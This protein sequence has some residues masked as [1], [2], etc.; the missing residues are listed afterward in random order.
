MKVVNKCRVCQAALSLNFADLG[1]SPPAN[2]YL[3]PTE[4]PAQ[5]Y[6]LQALV[7]ESCLLVQLGHE[8]PPERLFRDYAYR[9]AF[10]DS[11]Q[12]HCQ[13]YAHQMLERL[14][15]TQQSLVI[16]IGSNDGTLLQFFSPRCRT[17][18]IEPA[19]NLADLAQAAGIATEQAF[20]G[21]ELAARLIDRELQA[22]LLI[23]N[24][25]LAH[26]PD[27]NSFVAGL[28]QLLKPE[29]LLTL[30][31]PHLL[32]LMRQNQYDTIYH[33]HVFY[34]S[35]N[36]AVAV[37]ARHGLTVWDAEPLTTH[38]GSLR[39]Y[40]GHQRAELSSQLV[41]ARLETLL[42]QERTAGLLEAQT[43]THF[44]AQMFKSKSLILECLQ[45]LAAQGLI[46]A[47][48]APAKANTLLNYCHIGPELMA[49]TVD[50]NPLKQGRLLP[51]SGIP[52]YAPEAL[53]HSRP[54]HVVIL[55]WNL[56]HEIQVQLAELSAAGSRLLT[57]IPWP[58]LL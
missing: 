25:V 18:G 27:L 13:E 1:L 33:E 34:F 54:A 42:A 44:Q 14:N 56:R 26:V 19:G 5:S 3:L 57:L 45:R 49:F 11:W 12:R 15:L 10:S 7:C 9:S 36:A 53:Q 20:F 17:L 32:E 16:E 38:G 52:I 55:P 51:G 46:A 40:V 2:D 41:S 43:Y 37:L 24:N 23:A 4:D 58:E 21:L 50:R 6:P 22:D 47:Y 30:E 48:G 39:L 8:L 31:F 35:L 28:A 29:G